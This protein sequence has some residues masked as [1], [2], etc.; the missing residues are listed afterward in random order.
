MRE[1]ETVRL[2][3]EELRPSFILILNFTY[4][5]VNI[6]QPKV[7]CILGSLLSD[8]LLTLWRNFVNRLKS[9][10][11]MSGYMR[12]KTSWSSMYHQLNMG[13]YR[14]AGVTKNTHSLKKIM[15]INNLV[16]SEHHIMTYKYKINSL[17]YFSNI[18]ILW[19]STILPLLVIT[20]FD[21]W[22]I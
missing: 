8:I 12:V 16:T 17:S 20:N 15:G 22:E 3:R 11:V 19:F 7:I 21:K 14:A 6:M 2:F 1:W 9:Q 4:F 13:T 5:Q 10:K 18:L